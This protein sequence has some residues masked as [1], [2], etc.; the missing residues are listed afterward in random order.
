MDNNQQAIAEFWARLAS[1]RSLE[2]LREG[3][4]LL[5]V[6]DFKNKV[7]VWLD[8]S[9]QK[10]DCPFDLTFGLDAPL[11]RA[12]TLLHKDARKIIGDLLDGKPVEA[13]SEAMPRLTW[14]L[15]DGIL[16]E[17]AV[18]SPHTISRLPVPE[19]CGHYLV[20]LVQTVR[21]RPFPF[22]RCPVCQS[23]FVRAGKKMYCSAICTIRAAE[24]ARKDSKREYMREYMAKK[25]KQTK[26]RKG[27]KEG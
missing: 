19:I 6:E 22:R 2:G 21:F 4:R 3:E 11:Y 18:D 5:L 20:E 8:A 7:L 17:Q 24:D 9:L 15:K 25:R 26:A 1:I 10:D 16:Q 23:V 14:V 13:P 12:L 27:R